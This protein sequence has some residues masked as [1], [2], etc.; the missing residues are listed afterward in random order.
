[1]WYIHQLQLKFSNLFLTKPP[2]IPKPLFSQNHP[3]FQNSFSE[4]ALSLETT[5]LPI[6][7]T[8]NRSPIQYGWLDLTITLQHLFFLSFSLITLG[9]PFSLSLSLSLILSYPYEKLPSQRTVYDLLSCDSH[10]KNL[11]VKDDDNNEDKDHD[12]A[13]DSSS[14]KLH[15][16][17]V[18]EI[19]RCWEELWGVQ[20]NLSQFKLGYCEWQK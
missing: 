8:R 14:F 19:E 17:P 11:R 10:M 4:N 12:A 20:N 9:H 3:S 5:H 16:L 6:Q 7:R 18:I 1:M 15:N 13:S 2:I